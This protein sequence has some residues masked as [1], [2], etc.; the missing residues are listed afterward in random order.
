MYKRS[1][2]FY[3]DIIKKLFMDR[4]DVKGVLNE[5]SIS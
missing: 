1:K 4:M 2:G 5:P 3:L